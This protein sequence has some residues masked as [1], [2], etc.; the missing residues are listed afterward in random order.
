MFKTINT[1]KELNEFF[2]NKS[3]KAKLYNI[4]TMAASGF[5]DGDS[6]KI[7]KVFPLTSFVV[8]YSAHDSKSITSRYFDYIVKKYKLLDYKTVDVDKKLY[9]I[10]LINRDGN[11]LVL[12]NF[13]SSG[14][15]TEDM[16]EWIADNFADIEN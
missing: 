15:L 8:D 9:E 2:S 6:V 5:I 4:N 11:V 3:S 7:E 14:E 13:W 10:K 12:N 1:R 16:A